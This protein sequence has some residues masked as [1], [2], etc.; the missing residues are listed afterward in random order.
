MHS[1]FSPLNEQLTCILCKRALA[2]RL[3]E[4][5]T[6]WTTVKV[7]FSQPFYLCMSLPTWVQLSAPFELLQ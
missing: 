1:S 2:D 6:Q 3:K 4:V 5:I 7:S